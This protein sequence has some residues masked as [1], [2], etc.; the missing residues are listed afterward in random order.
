MSYGNYFFPEA[1]TTFAYHSKIV[2]FLF[3]KYSSCISSGQ[4]SEISS[5][6]SGSAE[7]FLGK[8]Y[9]GPEKKTQLYFE[10]PESRLALTITKRGQ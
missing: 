5:I 6:S 2:R 10:P 4:D 9:L 8:N 3:T 1:W 7:Y